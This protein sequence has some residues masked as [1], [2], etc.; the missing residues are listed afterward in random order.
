MAWKTKNMHEPANEARSTLRPTC[1]TPSDGP[2]KSSLLA[3]M[4]DQEKTKYEEGNAPKNEKIKRR[5]KG[6]LKSTL[7]NS[8][9]KNLQRARRC[10]HWNIHN[11]IFEMMVSGQFLLSRF[12]NL[13]ESHAHKIHRRS[14]IHAKF[15]ICTQTHF[16][17]NCKSHIAY[18]SIFLITLA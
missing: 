6:E 9:R 5:R 2:N 17:N 4:E 13:N 10:T 3:Q 8:C 1:E 12:Q 14:F 7:W 15:H 16:K 18:I 11:S